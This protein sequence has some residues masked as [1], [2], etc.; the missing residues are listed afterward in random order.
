MGLYLG[1][2]KINNISAGMPEIVQGIDTSDATATADDILLNKTAYANG[3]KITGNIE[4]LSD[5]TIYAS[6]SFDSSTELLKL[7]NTFTSK[8]FI[9]TNYT[10]TM[11]LAGSKLGDATIS[12][13]CSGTTFSSKNG[14]KLTGTGFMPA[15]YGVN[16]T[17]CPST[18]IFNIT[19]TEGVITITNQ[20]I[21][22][23]LINGKSFPIFLASFLIDSNYNTASMIAYPV[24]NDKN[25]INN[26]SAIQYIASCGTSNGIKF[27]TTYFVFSEVNGNLTLTWNICDSYFASD[28]YNGQVPI[29]VE[30]ITFGT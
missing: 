2:E 26:I 21:I 8:K 17:S 27:S 6:E 7:S 3:K 30:M 24:S 13:V 28:A 12:Q 15:T 14:L 4:T 29:R 10:M 20:T 9:P 25:L 1:K 18:N 19:A 5:A 16:N 11:G 22:D 23:Y